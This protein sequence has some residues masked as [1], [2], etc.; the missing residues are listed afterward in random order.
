MLCRNFKSRLDK[1]SAA[2]L[3]FKT[4]S[5]TLKRQAA[6]QNQSLKNSVIFSSHSST[7]PLNLPS[8][9]DPLN[10]R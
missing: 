6:N 5:K 3:K 7:L 9:C 4:H 8:N 10:V 1:Q 2:D